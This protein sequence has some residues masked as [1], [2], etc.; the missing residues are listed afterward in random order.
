MKIMKHIGVRW[1]F[2]LALFVCFLLANE[3]SF[4]FAA[5][6]KK[7]EEKVVHGVMIVSL[8][9]PLRATIGN[10]V[11]IEVVVGNERAAKIT[12]ILTVTCPTTKQLIGREAETLDSLS[13]QKIVYTWN[14]AGFTEGT[15]IIQAEVEKVPDET[16]FDD[17][18]RK[19]EVLLV[20]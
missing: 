3:S 5:E 16:D 15:Y 13:S 7:T 18:I 1:I 2:A 10:K 4:S 12:T 11:N 8:D 20:R 14:T 19:V 6:K 9:A 17:N